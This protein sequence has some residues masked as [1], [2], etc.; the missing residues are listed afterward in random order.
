MKRSQFR[1]TFPSNSYRDTDE[2]T[3]LVEIYFR[4]DHI[5]HALSRNSL[6]W[7]ESHKYIPDVLRVEPKVHFHAQ[8]SIL[9]AVNENTSN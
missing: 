7:E 4:N 3:S 6:L 9:S 1:S 5:D 2:S 8:H